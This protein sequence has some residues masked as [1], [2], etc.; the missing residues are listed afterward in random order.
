MLS[1]ISVIQYA[2]S[3]SSCSIVLCAMPV[4]LCKAKAFGLVVVVPEYVSTTSRNP[5]V[6][7]NLEMCQQIMVVMKVPL[8]G[9]ILATYGEQVTRLRETA[10]SIL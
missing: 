2:R 9:R 6:V 5:S 4:I 10:V 7:P 8:T 3:S 1:N